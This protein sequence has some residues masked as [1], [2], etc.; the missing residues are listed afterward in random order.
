MSRAALMVVFSLAACG[1][2]GTTELVEGTPCTT[3]DVGRCVELS[4]PGSEPVE[5]CDGEDGADGARGPE[6]APGQDGQEGAQGDP[7]PQGLPGQDAG[8]VE[9]VITANVDARGWC[10]IP[11]PY[12]NPFVLLTKAFVCNHDV[13]CVEVFDLPSETVPVHRIDVDA[14]TTQSCI[15]VWELRE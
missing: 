11:R 13:S 4:C 5:V 14:D 3:Q 15:G 7:G 12:A 10:D 1:S 8:G 9:W 6:G 2:A